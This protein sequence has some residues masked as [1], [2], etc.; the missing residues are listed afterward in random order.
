MMAFKKIV[1]LFFMISI[2]SCAQDTT[3]NEDVVSYLNSNGTSSQYEFAY[4]ELLTM[5]E[6][7][8]PKSESNTKGWEYLDTSKEKYVSEMTN[9]LVPVYQKNFT[10]D[11]LKKMA[12]FYR[13]EAGKQLTADRSKMTEE[14]KAELSDFYKSEVGKKIIDKQPVLSKEIATVS[15]DWSRDLYETALSLLK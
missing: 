2:T 9:L 15:E 5:L 1:A 8:Y 10:Q 7:Q 13:S 6:N 14:Q 3:F 4:D 12:D 11:E